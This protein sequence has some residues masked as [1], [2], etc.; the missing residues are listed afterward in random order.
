MFGIFEPIHDLEMD[1]IVR[2]WEIAQVL[3][4]PP[5]KAM[6]VLKTEPLPW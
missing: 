3:F 6:I 1:V 5:K 4:F 2:Q